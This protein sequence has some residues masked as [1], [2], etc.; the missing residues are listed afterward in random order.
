MHQARTIDTKGR[1]APP[2]IGRAQKQLRHLYRGVRLLRQRCQVRLWH[3]LPGRDLRQRA[4][5]AS[6]SHL[7]PKGQRQGIGCFDAGLGKGKAA[8]GHHMVGGQGRALRQPF[9][10]SIAHIAGA[11]TRAWDKPKGL[12]FMYFQ[13]RKRLPHQHLPIKLPGIRGGV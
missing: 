5:F 13:H 7:C 9:G 3:K 1:I 4:L 8:N 6:Y 10:R 12:P 11:P 2:Q